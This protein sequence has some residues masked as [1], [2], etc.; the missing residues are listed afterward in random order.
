MFRFVI[1]VLPFLCAFLLL[2]ASI[3]YSQR[4]PARNLSFAPGTTIEITNPNGQIL[5]Q[6]HTEDNLNQIHLDTK[7]NNTFTKR[8]N[9]G[10]SKSFKSKS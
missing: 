9:V 3:S 1:R 2:A 5:L 4:P 10:R 7:V 6:A 8:E